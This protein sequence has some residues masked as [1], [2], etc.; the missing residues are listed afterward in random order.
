MSVPPAVPVVPA[1]ADGAGAAAV[2]ASGP[3]P[4]RL[5][6]QAGVAH[7]ADGRAAGGRG[8]GGGRGRGHAGRGAGAAAPAHAVGGVGGQG[9]APAGLPAWL[10][11][12]FDANDGV[13]GED[14]RYDLGVPDG[15]QPLS[16]R[17][18][19]YQA[20]V[21][22]DHAI[23]ALQSLARAEPLVKHVLSRWN[24]V[25]KLSMRHLRAITLG[26]V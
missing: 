12:A 10:A 18:R 6:Q 9:H 19:C 2:A 4:A 13:Q 1:A 24:R 8:S 11:G 16:V 21:C 20:G 5:N 14:F 7:G 22:M 15:T 23:I 17:V 3:Q 26:M 25:C